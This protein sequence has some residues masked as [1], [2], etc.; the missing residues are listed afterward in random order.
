MRENE[1]LP[2][3]D[4]ASLEKAFRAAQRF[5]ESPRGWVIFTGGYYTGQN[6][7]GGCHR[8]PSQISGGRAAIYAVTELLD[9]LRS[10]F[11]PSSSTSFDKVFEDVRTAAC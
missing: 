9:H 1:G 10:T 4:M 5:A 2:R 6:A 3:E 11:S 7:P 8:Q